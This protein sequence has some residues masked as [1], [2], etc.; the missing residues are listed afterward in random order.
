MTFSPF[1]QP[2]PRG[3]VVS[4]GVRRLGSPAVADLLTFGALSHLNLLSDGYERT[5]ERLVSLLGVQINL[6]IPARPGDDT[7]AFLFTLGGVITEAFCPRGVAER[8]QGRL[9]GLY[10]EHYLGAEMQV[11]DLAAAREICQRRGIRIIRDDGDVFFTHPGACCG[12]AWE[13]FGGDFHHPPAGGTEGD[14][15]VPPHWTPLKPA[16]WWRDEHPLGVVGLARVTVAVR[17]LAAATEQF[18]GLVAA[19]IVDKPAR[20]GADAVQLQV[21]D[22]VFELLA[23]TEDSSLG[24]FLERYG[25]RMR[26][27]VYRVAD[28]G[29]VEAH[30]AALGLRLEPG[31]A[32]DAVAL[33]PAETLNLRMEFTEA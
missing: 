13:V 18:R 23:P 7:D 15:G 21:G 33:P 14:E 17:N 22:T 2:V 9:L 29:R 11:D 32:E 30:A 19:E 25:E 6:E 31:D 16:A 26:T 4:G 5:K 8:G 27:T 12:V 10:G 28:L 1:R 20:A 24:A 3:H